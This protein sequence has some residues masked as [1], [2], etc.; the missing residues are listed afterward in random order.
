MTPIQITAPTQIFGRPLTHVA[1]RADV[2]RLQKLIEHG[3]IYLDAD[4]LVQRDFDD[5]LDYPAVL[6]REGEEGL[7]GT[8]NA[9]ILAEPGAEFLKR[10]LAEYKSFRS[11]GRDEFWN[12]HSVQVPSRLARQHPTEIRLLSDKAFFWPLW[13]DDHLNWIFRTDR[14]IPLEETYANHLWEARAWKY[15]EGLTPRHLRSTQNNFSTWSKPLLE[16][17]PDNYGA[18]N[19]F[20]R[21]RRLGNGLIDKGR[22][23]KSSV[24]SRIRNVERRV[25]RLK[26]SPSEA[27][28]DIFSEVYSEKLWGYDDASRFFS[29]V[30][31]RGRAA[32]DYVQKMSQ[33]LSGHAAELG[34]PLT[35]VDLGCG[36]FYV[37]RALFESMPGARYIGCDIVPSLIEHNRNNYGSD[38][39]QF[40]VLDIVRDTLPEGDVCL[41]RQVFQHLSNAD[42][43]EFLNRQQYALLYVTEGHPAERT[44]RFNPDKTAGS[45]VRFDWR[46]GRGRGVELDKPP[47]NRRSV[48]AFQ[49]IAP[50]NEIIVTERIVS[51]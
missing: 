28:R 18:S 8:A 9:V 4:V 7:W 31:S 37:G 2:V 11:T 44:G 1:H 19:L 46:T 45:D 22:R 36:D 47:F 27:R 17:V 20:V 5:L 48:E 13:S 41:V 26:M 3:G 30:G 16:G 49:T 33:I 32:R 25:S 10:W 43:S 35:I 15:L 14:P 21:V 40:Q 24:R 23:V 12:E 6:G 38:R 29:G 42:I 34:R 50:P 51:P 39:V